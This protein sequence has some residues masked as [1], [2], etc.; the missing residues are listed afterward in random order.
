MIVVPLNTP[1][2]KIIQ[3]ERSKYISD[4]VVTGMYDDPINRKVIVHTE[5]H[6]RL[7]LWE[8]DDYDAIGQWT[9]QDVIDKINELYNS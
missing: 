4:V 6:G 5:N 7:I 9:D 8:A 3:P 1:Y 2:T